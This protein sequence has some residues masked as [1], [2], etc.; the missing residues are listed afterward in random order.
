MQLLY[1][2]V[3]SAPLNGLITAFCKNILNGK[4]QVPPSGI[5]TF[6]TDD[7]TEVK[8]STNQTCHVTKVAYYEGYKNYEYTDF[9][10]RLI[11]S[12][13]TFFDIGC[14]IGYYSILGA[15]HNPELK[16]YAFDP[17]PGPFHYLKE[18]IRL[19]GL[20]ARVFASEIAIS[21]SDG[22]TEFSIAANP[23]YTYLKFNSLG[24]GG[25]IST[26]RNSALTMKKQVTTQKLDTFVRKNSIPRIDIIKMDTENSEHMVIRGGLET[27]K[28]QQPIII[29]EVFSSEMSTLVEEA[30]QGLGY[31][32]YLLDDNHPVRIDSLTSGLENRIH[33]ILLV[34]P[35]KA[36][37]V[38]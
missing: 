15:L 1:K 32:L 30:I 4:V 2:A 19:N 33:N 3:Y 29:T 20:E 25:H 23:K 34:P 6:R 17:S 11:K 13:K 31:S 26:V 16:V 35:D 14:N 7:G 24:G 22:Q 38:F 5:M 37:Q 12:Q 36:G 10:L 9:F 28:S 21:D 8:L 18:N 27:I